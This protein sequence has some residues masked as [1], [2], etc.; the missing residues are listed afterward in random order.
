MSTSMLNLALGVD[1]KS[2]P[3]ARD[4]HYCELAS[5]RIPTYREYSWILREYN[6]YVTMIRMMMIVVMMATISLM[7]VIG[8]AAA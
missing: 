5:R 6:I 4:I 8:D 1:S 3:A 7:R 2:T